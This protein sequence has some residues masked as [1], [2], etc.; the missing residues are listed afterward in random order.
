MFHTF[1]AIDEAFSHRISFNHFMERLHG[2]IHSRISFGVGI[3]ILCLLGL[4]FFMWKFDHH[5]DESVAQLFI[6]APLMLAWFLSIIGV[7]KIIRSRKEKKSF[8]WY[9][10]LIVNGTVLLAALIAIAINVA[11]I[12]KFFSLI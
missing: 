10:G 5:Q 11:I 7:S 8:Q 6:G 9:F 2:S 1:D 12:A 4:S 3:A